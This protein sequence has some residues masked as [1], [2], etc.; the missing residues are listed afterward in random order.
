M[1]QDF[2]HPPKVLKFQAAQAGI[3]IRHFRSSQAVV[4]LSVLDGGH[5]PCSR[6]PETLTT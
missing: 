4:A 3:F 5:W 2:G 6:V 1:R